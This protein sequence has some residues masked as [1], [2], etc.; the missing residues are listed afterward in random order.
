MSDATRVAASTSGLDFQ[1]LKFKR[2]TFH[3]TGEKPK[4]AQRDTPGPETHSDVEAQQVTDHSRESRQD[5][6]PGE[7][8][9]QR[10]H[11]QAQ[12]SE[13][14]IQLLVEIGGILV[15]IRPLF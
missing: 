8:I 7:V 4:H 9:D 6:H 1:Q 2:V 5:D 12:Q 15:V 10:V 14:S 13:R 3:S 11:G